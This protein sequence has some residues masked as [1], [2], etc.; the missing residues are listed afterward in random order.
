M[1]CLG[2]CL[3][4]SITREQKSSTGVGGRPVVFYGLLALV[5]SELFK[6]VMDTIFVGILAPW[7]T[8]IRN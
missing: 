8:N 2:V 6:N 4:F 3:I 7:D 1:F 5:H